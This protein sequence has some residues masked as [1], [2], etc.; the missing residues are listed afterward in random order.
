VKE[1][2][3]TKSVFHDV[4]VSSSDSIAKVVHQS[5]DWIK[6]TG[7]ELGGIIPAAGVANPGKIIDK[8]GSPLDMEMFDFVMN[9][10]VRGV[11]DLIRQFLPYW[12][13]TKPDDPDGERGV[14]VLVSSSAAFDGQPG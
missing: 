13:Q 12:I 9:I 6:Q 14:I 11:I 10:N 8:D 3:S 5:L 4:D 1:L 2:G 7:H